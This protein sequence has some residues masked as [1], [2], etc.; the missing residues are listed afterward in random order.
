MTNDKE[1]DFSVDQTDYYIEL[2]DESHKV[3]DQ[4][5]VTTDPQE[6]EQLNKR[7]LEI[8]KWLAEISFSNAWDE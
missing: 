1:D 4:M 6:R 8:Q 5:L 3:A 2:L 7:Y